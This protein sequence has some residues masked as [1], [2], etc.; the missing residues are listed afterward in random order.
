MIA[1]LMPLIGVLLCCFGTEVG[2]KRS[3]TSTAGGGLSSAALTAKIQSTEKI[4]LIA[5]LLY[6]IGLLLV[7]SIRGSLASLQPGLGAGF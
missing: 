1:G 7:A 5:G 3:N 6:L 2:L 4:P